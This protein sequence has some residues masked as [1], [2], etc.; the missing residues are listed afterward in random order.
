MHLSSSSSLFSKSCSS[1][2]LWVR[3]CSVRTWVRPEALQG[4]L[5]RY[6]E[7]MKSIVESH[8]GSGREGDW[9]RGDGGVRRPTGSRGRRPENEQQAAE[10]ASPQA[11]PG[12]RPEAA[13]AMLARGSPRGQL[14]ISLASCGEGRNTPPSARV[15][16]PSVS[17]SHRRVVRVCLQVHASCLEPGPIRG[18]KV[19]LCQ[20]LERELDELGRRPHL[21]GGRDD[22]VL[23]SQSKCCRCCSA[24]LFSAPRRTL[25]FFEPKASD[26]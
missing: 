16:P 4:L 24:R 8:G 5:A 15:P 23:A 6:F 19:H 12:D 7:R 11:P 22:S 17:C 20:Q 2:M 3:R 18:A 25:S 26:S 10:W 13:S 14:P 1:A 9:R 21:I